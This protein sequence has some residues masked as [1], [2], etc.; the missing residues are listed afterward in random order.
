MTDVLSSLTS[1]EWWRSAG[2]VLDYVVKI[3]AVGTVAQ[4][5]KPSSSS[6]WLLAILF[7]PVIGLPLFLMMGSPYINRRRHRIQMEAQAMVGTP[8]AEMPAIPEGAELSDEVASVV[9]LND[10]LTDLPAV[11]SRFHGLYPDYHGSIAAMAAAVD[12]AENTVHAQIYIVAWDETTDVF[13]SACRR[14]AARGVAVRLLFDQVGSWKYP[15]YRKLGRRLTEAG[16]DWHL[17]MPLKPFHWRFRRPDLRNH[18]KLL[19]IDGHTGFIGSQNMIEPGYL[20]RRNHRSGR[21]WVDIMV[22]LSGPVVEAMEMIF[23]VDWYQETDTIIELP[24]R[25]DTGP[26]AGDEIVQLVPSGPGYA[27]EPN[28]RL[29]NSMVHH[30]KEHLI[31]CSPYFIP[32]DS[33]MEAILTAC[34]RGVR[35]DLLVNE[36]SDQFMVGHA[37]ASYYKMLMEAGVHIHRYPAPMILHT[38]FALADPEGDTIGVLGSSNMDMRSFGLNYEV[39]L[40]V[41]S[42]EISRELTELAAVYLDRCTELTHEQ[43]SRRGLGKRYLDNAMRLTA[44]LQ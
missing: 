17:T 37:Q 13:F 21:E 7:V 10:T 30:A 2:L 35:V 8:M 38:K 40:M 39:T 34:Y 9:R 44:A 5:R 36:V 11:Y 16:I 43:W 25:S 26:C 31:L 6:A 1:L 18:R 20:S 3:I 28:L 29:F 4:D 33:L 22:K 42:G 32:D 23:A 19:I 41:V 14:A 24:A 27:T 15:G 12:A